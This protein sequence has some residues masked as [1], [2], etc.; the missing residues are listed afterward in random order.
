M[1]L[2]ETKEAKNYS[3]KRDTPPNIDSTAKRRGKKAFA[4]E[5]FIRGRVGWGNITITSSASFIGFA[6][7]Q[8]NIFAASLF[9]FHQ[10]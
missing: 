4:W 9:V 7:R 6:D 5:K 8:P 1:K 2:R 10:M 3:I